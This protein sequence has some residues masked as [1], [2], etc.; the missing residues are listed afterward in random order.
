MAMG[1]P[2]KPAPECRE[3][4]QAACIEAKERFGG[5]Y[6][7]LVDGI[8]DLVISVNDPGECNPFVTE[9]HGTAIRYDMPLTAVLHFNPPTARNPGQKKSYW[10]S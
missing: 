4:L 10:H 7:T 6:A 9:L 8:A 3:L 5:I 2:G 1:K